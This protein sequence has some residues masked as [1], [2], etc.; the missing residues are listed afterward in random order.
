MK[1]YD[2]AVTFSEFPDEISLCLNISNCPGHCESC[3]EPWLLEDVGTVLTPSVLEN[4]IKSNPGITMIGF[5]GGDR[6]HDTIKTLASWIHQQTG[7]KVG[8]YSGQ[9]YLDMNLLEELDYYKIG[10][11]IRPKGPV[12]TWHTM[13]CG[14][15]KFPF[16]NQLMFKRENNKWINITASFRKDKISDYK[17]EIV[18]N[19]N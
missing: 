13:N 3:S 18:T 10:R 8:M 6:D 15:L 7:L 12:E 19:E 1:F 9:E 16:S 5:M 2:Y 17:R 4:L 11:W 14:P